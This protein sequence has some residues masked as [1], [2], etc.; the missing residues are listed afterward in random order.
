MKALHDALPNFLDSFVRAREL[1][2]DPEHPA[3]A[4]LVAHEQTIARLHRPR[5]RGSRD[6][7]RRAL[8]ERYLAARLARLCLP[9]QRT[10]VP[11][12]RHTG[13]VSRT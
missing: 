7:E 10:H 5:A 12:A 13:V 2:D 6:V 8:L 11:L 1:A 4:A 9:R 3:L